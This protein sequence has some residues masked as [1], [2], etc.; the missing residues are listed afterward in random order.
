MERKVCQPVRGHMIIP[1]CRLGPQALKGQQ[2][3]AAMWCSRSNLPGRSPLAAGVPWGHAAGRR[4]FLLLTAALWPPS[5]LPRCLWS[6]QS[7][8]A[9]F[10]PVWPR[11]CNILGKGPRGPFPP[12]I[13]KWPCSVPWEGCWKRK[14]LAN[15]EPRV[16]R[17]SDPWAASASCL[18]SATV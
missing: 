14:S 13:R 5:A 18:F 4:G 11:G 17:F 9:S 8:H 10:S 3:L 2:S 1:H 15:D 6:P 16:S 7:P 12:I